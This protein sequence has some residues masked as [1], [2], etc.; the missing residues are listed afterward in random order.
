[1]TDL[2]EL[3]CKTKLI[4]WDEAPMVNMPCV[5]ALDRSLRDVMRKDRAFGGR[6]IAFGGDYRQILP[7]VSKGSRADI[8]HVSLTSSYIWRYH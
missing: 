1:M 3:L 2:T 6:P 5:E 8:V 4:I 7:V